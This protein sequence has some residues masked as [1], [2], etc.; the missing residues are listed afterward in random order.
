MQQAYD[1]VVNDGL[2]VHHAATE[3]GVPKST[4]GDK[5]SGHTNTIV[6]QARG[7]LGSIFDCMCFNWLCKVE[8]GGFNTDESSI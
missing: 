2:S 1:A 4:L 8:N 3:Y 7:V 5:V 6:R